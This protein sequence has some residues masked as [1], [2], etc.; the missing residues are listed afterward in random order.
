MNTCGYNNNYFLHGDTARGG[1]VYHKIYITS[2]YFQQTGSPPAYTYFYGGLRQDTSAR[3]VYFFLANPPKNDT[4]L[5]D[6]NLNA[7]DTLPPSFTNNYYNT[8]RN[9]VSSIDSVLVGPNYRKRYNI[10]C[11]Q[12]PDYASLIEGIGSTQGITSLLSPPFESGDFLNCFTQNAV[13]QYTNPVSPG[14]CNLHLSIRDLQKDGSYSISISPTPFTSHTTLQAATRF[15]NAVIS[16][17]DTFGNQ[18]RQ[19]KNVSG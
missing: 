15:E 4:L 6:F 9:Y 7:G 18:V 1:H 2:Q 14:I 10:S 13:T 8:P 3:K 17:Y 19:I 5:Y 11:S 12:N 16:L